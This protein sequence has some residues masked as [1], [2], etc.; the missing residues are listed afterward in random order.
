MG[1]L[2]RGFWASVA[3]LLHF[4][5]AQ[6]GSLRAH[7]HALPPRPRAARGRRLRARDR[8]AGRG[9]PPRPREDL[10]PRGAWPCLLPLRPLRPGRR[11]VRG[12][13]RVPPGQRLRPLLP[14]PRPQQD[15]PEAPR[16]PPPRPRLELAARS[17]RLP[18]LPPP[19]GRVGV[20]AASWRG[21]VWPP[22]GAVQPA[23]SFP[24]SADTARLASSPVLHRPESSGI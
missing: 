19:A 22:R 15:R 9:R 23:S 1:L 11:R 24:A 12:R 14:R 17:P 20:S 21:A 8:A 3:C 4:G 5:N 6:R 10:D 2:N 18:L 13:G 16:P 7:L